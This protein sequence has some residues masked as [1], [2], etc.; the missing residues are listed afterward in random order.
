MPSEQPFLS[1]FDHFFEPSQCKPQK[2]IQPFLHIDHVL[3]LF[4]SPDTNEDT[5]DD[6]EHE[7]GGDHRSK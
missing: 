7:E 6:D 4:S 3:P 5:N 1:T 2:N